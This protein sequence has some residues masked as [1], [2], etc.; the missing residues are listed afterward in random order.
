[1][2]ETSPTLSV[3]GLE[4]PGLKPIDF[5]LGPGDCVSLTGPS[6]SGKSLFLRALADLDARDGAIE[7]NG[8]AYDTISGPN[9][10]RH[11]GYL[12]TE[13]SWWEEIVGAHFSTHDFLRE[14]ASGLGLDTNCGDWPVNHLSTGEKQ[15][16]ALLRLLAGQPQVLLLDEPTSA[17]DDTATTAVEAMIAERLKTGASCI[18]V[19]HDKAQA[20]RI[21]QRHFAI[22]AGELRERVT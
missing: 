16:L 11:V 1:M 6:G 3:A 8:T 14:H 9:W 17:L 21:A 2:T 18:W 4:I 19:S 10:R 12:A 7:L 13:A 5:E 22:E 15:R 20:R